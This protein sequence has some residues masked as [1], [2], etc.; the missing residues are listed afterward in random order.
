MGRIFGFVIGAVWLVFVFVAFSRSSEGWGGGH[1]DLGFWWGVIG[2]LLT[3][4]A[5]AAFLGTWI[6]TRSRE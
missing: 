6:H 3:G 2:V 1:S 4:A 5:T